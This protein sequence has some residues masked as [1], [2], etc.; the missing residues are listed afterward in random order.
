MVQ[1]RR[2]L[3]HVLAEERAQ[4]LD[5]FVRR[6][7][8]VALYAELD[9]RRNGCGGVGLEGQVL[10]V[11]QVLNAVSWVTRK[12]QLSDK[13]PTLMLFMIPLTMGDTLSGTFLTATY[14]AANAAETLTS[15]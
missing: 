13:K 2:R 3:F 12:C 15:C 9:E 7:A 4:V 1:E 8:K 11:L 6:L 14:A 10:L 5:D